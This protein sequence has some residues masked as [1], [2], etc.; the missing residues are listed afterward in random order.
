MS[1]FGDPGGPS[2]TR[3]PRQSSA[4]FLSRLKQKRLVGDDS[5]DYEDDGTGMEDDMEYNPELGKKRCQY[6]SHLC[7]FQFECPCFR[8]SPAEVVD[9]M[10]EDSDQEME[11]VEDLIGDESSEEEITVRKNQN[12]SKH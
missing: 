12:E 4:K 1:D 7:Y 3:P 9:M 5:D 11:D 8:K 10:G 2:G 6:L